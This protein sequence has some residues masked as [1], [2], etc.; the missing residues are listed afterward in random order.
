MLMNLLKLK[1]QMLLCV[2]LSGMALFGYGQM[3][4]TPPSTQAGALMRSVNVPVNFYT[5][6]ANIN[7]PLYGISLKSLQVPVQ[8]CYQA[9][10]I[11]VNDAAT[12]VG[13]GWRL[14][15]GGRISRMVKG[16][17]A[18]E[19]GFCKPPVSSSDGYIAQNLP[20][21]TLKTTG[22]RLEDKFDSESDLF[23]FEFPGGTGRFMVDYDGRA[24]EMPYQNLKIEWFDKTLPSSYF[25]ITD[26][27]GIQ[28]IFKA[29]ETSM[30]KQESDKENGE[31]ELEYY[32]SSWNLTQII[33][34]NGNKIDFTYTSGPV[35]YNSMQN[36]YTTMENDEEKEVETK[37]VQIT[38]YPQY[39]KSIVWKNGKIEF[40]SDSIRYG[41]TYVI[42][43]QELRI[44]Q[45]DHDVR[46]FAFSYGTFD[47][48]S[49]KLVSVTEKNEGTE[50]DYYLF[51]YNTGYS[52][53][54]R[55]SRNTDHFGYYNGPDSYKGYDY[56]QGGYNDSLPS[57]GDDKEPHWPYTQADML[58]EI[59]YK[60]GGKKVFDYEE[61]KTDICT[62]AGVRIKQI[63]EYENSN[64]APRSTK[65]IYLKSNTDGTL[66]G[67]SSGEVYQPQVDY[68]ISN[69]NII[70]SGRHSY[71]ILNSNENSLYDVSGAAIVYSEVRE[72]LPNGAYNIYKYSTFSTEYC[73]GEKPIAYEIDKTGIHEETRYRRGVD[74]APLT[75]YFYKRGLP[76]EQSSYSASGE[77]IYSTINHYNFN[78][79][80]KHKISNYAIGH[81]IY[82]REFGTPS[83]QLD[84]MYRLSNYTW[85]SQPI[86][87]DSTTILKGH[88]N[89]PVSTST[90]YDTTYLSPKTIVQKDVE[91]NQIVTQT[92]YSFDYGTQSGFA[93]PMQSAL[94]MMQRHHM[95]AVPIEKI[96]YKNGKIVGGEL[97]LFRMSDMPDSTVLVD[98]KLALKLSKPIDPVAFTESSID[99]S[100]HFTYDSRYEETMIFDKYDNWGNPTCTH[101]P[102][103]SYQA[104]IYGY[105]HSLPIARVKNARGG[106]PEDYITT[107][108]YS[109]TANNQSPVVR[110]FDLNTDQTISLE[111]D[112]SVDSSVVVGTDCIVNLVLQNSTTGQ[113]V[114]YTPTVLSGTAAK[115]NWRLS[116]TM[117][118]TAGSQTMTLNVSTPSLLGWTLTGRYALSQLHHRDERDKEVFHTSFEDMAEGTESPSAKTGERVLSSTYSVDLRNFIPGSYLLSYWES[119]NNG[120]SWQRVQQILEVTEASTSY[121]LS[122]AG[123]IIDELRIQP[124]GSEMTTYTHLPGVGMTSQTDSNGHTTY[125]EYDALGR[126]SAIR[127]NERRLLKSY[128]Y[129]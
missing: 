14:S 21:W 88:Y 94:T 45:H 31:D 15:A 85:Y 40:L 70:V 46:S 54:S 39:L 22:Q 111:L 7:I 82:T 106:G 29:I 35:Q 4:I 52:L 104:V 120:A 6:V 26:D 27:A 12:W 75:T 108:D 107:Q 101:A 5:G 117:P 37:N 36:V 64:S 105:D 83:S 44:S 63:K 19:K 112:L 80:I 95:Q 3:N 32:P 128:Q 73:N 25:K 28:Y 62:S 48:G 103:G 41:N 69:S 20:Q 121:E 61:Q 71:I 116:F 58:T 53:P 114:T 123:K 47:N 91:N 68:A 34:Y 55:S 59:R 60:G 23:Y 87:L 66:T 79:P 72:V 109:F 78:A 43:L 81:K 30:Y 122:A 89:L 84:S 119:S 126:L 8:L 92:T 2:L 50:G 125:Y 11:K 98:R 57:R 77:L 110:S 99:A 118:A 93:T 16:G 51:G 17:G 102:Y 97:T 74:G 42:R 49:L 65:Y 10:G 18:D 76:L 33:D 13:L 127:D 124:T 9:S 38:H 1:R 96:S 100:G 115:M 24:W 56:P 113:S 129:Q 67:N 86:Y 90:M